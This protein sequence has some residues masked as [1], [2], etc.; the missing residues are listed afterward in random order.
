MGP[1]GG[2]GIIILSHCLSSDVPPFSVE[3]ILKLD[4]YAESSDSDWERTL[5][6]LLNDDTDYDLTMVCLCMP[7]NGACVYMSTGLR[8]SSSL[9]RITSHPCSATV[10]CNLS[11]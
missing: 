1:C 6:V 5:F 4:K 10:I 8:V 11:Y 7:V 3:F 9:L 2:C